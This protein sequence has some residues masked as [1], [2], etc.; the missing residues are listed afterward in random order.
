M[1]G[2]LVDDAW[3]LSAKATPYAMIKDRISASLLSLGR[4][5]KLPLQ[6]LGRLRARA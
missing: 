4:V 3:S 2:H 1:R 5:L 6:R